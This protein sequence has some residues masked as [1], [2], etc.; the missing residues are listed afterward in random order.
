[1]PSIIDE[2]SSDSPDLV[3]EKEATPKNTAKAFTDS[4]KSI[5]ITKNW[6]PTHQKVVRVANSIQMEVK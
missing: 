5:L 6:Y 3:D 2:N 1:M 4:I